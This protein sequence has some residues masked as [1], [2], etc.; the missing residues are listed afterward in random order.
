MNKVYNS[1]A[2]A[3]ADIPDGATI[4]FGGW[5]L[6]GNPENLT[7][8][9]YEKGTKDITAIANNPGAIYK[10]IFYDLAILI[11]ANRVKKFIGSYHG[12]NYDLIEK[13]KKGEMEY[14]CIPQG[15]IAE[16]IR[17]AGAGLGGF[18]TR[19][20]ANS[21]LAEGKEKRIIDGKPYVLEFPLRADYAFVKAKTGDTW[22]NLIYRYTAQNFNPLMAMAGKVTIAEVENL[23]EIGELDPNHI[24]TPGIYVDRIVKGERYDKRV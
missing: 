19:A 21:S 3:I 18:Y 13:C 11:Q 9:L 6:V 2:D 5:G 15:T 4:M 20:G 17:T 10:G 24:H 1:A 14:E 7:R 22:G 8:A 12:W 23:S 16:R